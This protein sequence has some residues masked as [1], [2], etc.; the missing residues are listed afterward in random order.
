MSTAL[1]TSGLLVSRGNDKVSVISQQDSISDET[2]WTERLE[3]LLREYQ[4]APIGNL[5]VFRERARVALEIPSADRQ[6]LTMTILSN[7]ADI[8]KIAHKG[9]KI[10]ERFVSPKLLRH[11]SIKTEILTMGIER[12]F[13]DPLEFYKNDREWMRFVV[14]TLHGL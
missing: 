12:L 10:V 14:N 1:G 6:S 2:R 4:T 7:D 13:A 5:P 9:A 8:D 11:T 3:G